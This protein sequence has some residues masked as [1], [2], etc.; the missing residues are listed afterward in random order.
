VARIYLDR[1]EVTTIDNYKSPSQ[2]G[3][4]PY[5]IRGLPSGTHTLTIEATG[6]HNANARGSWVWLDAFDVVQ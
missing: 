4:V 5:S 2:T 3:T 1:A 6:T